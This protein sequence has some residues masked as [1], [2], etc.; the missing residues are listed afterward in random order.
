MDREDKKSPQ[1]LGFLSGSQQSIVLSETDWKR[2]E[3]TSM[4]PPNIIF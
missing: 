4:V 1:D 2:A 3:V